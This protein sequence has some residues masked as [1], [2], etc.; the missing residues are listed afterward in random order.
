[1]VMDKHVPAA[2]RGAYL[3]AVRDLLA[4][5]RRHVPTLCLR[6]AVMLPSDVTEE[7][8]E[9]AESVEFIHVEMQGRPQ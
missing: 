7:E 2:M 4:T 5:M 3:E 8:I 6:A 1:M 9:A